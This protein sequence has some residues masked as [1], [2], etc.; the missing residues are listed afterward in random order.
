MSTLLKL[1]PLSLYIHIPWCIKKCPYC[2]FNSHSTNYEEPPEEAYVTALIQDLEEDL[3]KIWGRP[4]ASIFI[5]GGT[6]SLFSAK[7]IER[8]LQAI[9]TRLAFNPLIEITLEANP[10][11]FEQQKFKDFKQI[12]I[13][14]LSIGVQ[15]FQNDKLNLL[16]RV[17]HGDEA[18]HAIEIAKEAGFINFNIDLMHGLPQQSVSDALFDLTTALSFS[19]P[20]LSWYQLT[21]EPNTAFAKFSPVLPHE[22]ILFEIQQQG[23]AFLATNGYEHYEISAYAKPNHQANHNLNYWQFGDYLGIGAGAHSKITDLASQ[24]IIRYTKTRNPKDYLD[25]TKS[26]TCH[27]QSIE[28]F[29]LPLEFMMNAL[30][31]TQGVSFDLFESRTGLAIHTISEQLRSAQQQGFLEKTFLK[32]TPLGQQFLNDCLLS[33]EST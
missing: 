27:S 33:F 18:K 19:P 13:N 22:E 24:T 21:I 1:P 31:L 4:I 25:K 17:H 20:H 28:T 2:D 6:P 14:R 8:L 26:F 29:D 11:T 30:R 15:S 9:H 10:G 5:G 3:A 32:T 7:A 12:G 16:G 23:H